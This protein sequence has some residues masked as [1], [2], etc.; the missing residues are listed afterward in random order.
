V[1]NFLRTMSLPF[2]LRVHAGVEITDEVFHGLCVRPFEKCAVLR[3]REEAAGEANA[4]ALAALPKGV[5]GN[6]AVSALAAHRLD[7][8]IAEE[9]SDLRRGLEFGQLRDHVL[10]G[11]SHCCLTNVVAIPASSSICRTRLAGPGRRRTW[12]AGWGV[13]DVS[14]PSSVFLILYAVTPPGTATVSSTVHTVLF[15]AQTSSPS[16]TWDH[17][18]GS[19]G[20]SS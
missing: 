14:V 9:T 17:V 13:V 16:A 5:L 3:V 8:Q 6:G 15:G 12:S 11:H 2:Q 1:L 7:A 19:N 20:A 10:R 18:E 4:R